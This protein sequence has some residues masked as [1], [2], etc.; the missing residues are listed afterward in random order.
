MALV[1]V[2][3]VGEVA[4]EVEVLEVAAVAV[5]KGIQMDRCKWI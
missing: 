5:A 2:M 1:A 3:V 4:V